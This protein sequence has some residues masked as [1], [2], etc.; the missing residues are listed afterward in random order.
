[1][2]STVLNRKRVRE[3]LFAEKIII[4]QI[5]FLTKKGKY[6]TIYLYQIIVLR[7]VS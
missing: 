1:M 4:C 7:S 2:P 6:V 3:K 5:Y